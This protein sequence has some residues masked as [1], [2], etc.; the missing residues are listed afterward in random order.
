M[1]RLYPSSFY[2]I[3]P[4]RLVFDPGPPNVEHVEPETHVDPLRSLAS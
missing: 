2:R 3:K 4:V 1:L